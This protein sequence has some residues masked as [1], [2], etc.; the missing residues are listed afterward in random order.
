[1]PSVLWRCC[2]GGRKG[3]RPVKTERWGSGMVIC[4]ERGADLHMI[5]LMPLP[6]TVSCF[7]KIRIGFTFLVWHWL[8]VRVHVLL[9]AMQDKE[10]VDCSWRGEPHVVRGSAGRSQ[11]IRRRATCETY[12]PRDRWQPIWIRS[13]HNHCS[14][15]QYCHH[16]L[17][18][19]RT[20]GVKCVSSYST[21]KF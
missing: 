5:Q 18:W 3:I 17:Q 12:R 10:P 13:N 7:S 20:C 4:L 16:G 11:E 1:M 15:R 19:V 9:C 2:L 21:H 6:F 14:A 8:C